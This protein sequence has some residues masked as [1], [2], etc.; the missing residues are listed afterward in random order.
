M[1]MSSP[2]PRGRRAAARAAVMA[3]PSLHG[4]FA[5]YFLS[6]GLLALALA[7]HRA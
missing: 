1:K 6:M 3:M 7:I 5:L 2:F 4:V